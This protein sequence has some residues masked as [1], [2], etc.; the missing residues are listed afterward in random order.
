MSKS[1]SYTYRAG[2]EAMLKHSQDTSC[3]QYPAP[4]NAQEALSILTSYLLG[5][6]WSI[7]DSINEEQ[8]NAIVVEHIL[9]QYSKAWLK[10]WKNYEK[11][12]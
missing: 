12:A 4:L 6:D 3:G 7:V 2:F 9:N 1:S 8:C 11:G 5:D 10:D